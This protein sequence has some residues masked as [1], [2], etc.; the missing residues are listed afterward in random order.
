M[1]FIL[2]IYVFMAVLGLCCFSLVVA[3]RGYSLVAAHG[4]LI[5]VTYLV[6][7]HRL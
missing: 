6:A 2:F 7:E 3:I 4:L 5:V 1:Y